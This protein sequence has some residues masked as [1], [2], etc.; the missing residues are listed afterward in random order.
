M[1]AKE[2]RDTGERLIPEGNHKTLTYGEHLARYQSVLSSVKGKV[3]ADIASGAGY[4]T[5]LLASMA[6]TI[7]GI[8]YSEEAIE[9]SKKLYHFLILWYY[10]YI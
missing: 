9:Y 7:T 10:T 2:L 6:K 1:K 8:D 4:G 5:N 3:V